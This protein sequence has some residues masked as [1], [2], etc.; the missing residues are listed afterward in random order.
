MSS[1]FEPPAMGRH[2]ARLFVR[3][4]TVNTANAAIIP[5]CQ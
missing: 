1:D 3:R 2:G 5:A 4:V